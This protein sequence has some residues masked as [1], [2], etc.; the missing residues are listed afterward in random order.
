MAF[1]DVIVQQAFFLILVKVFEGQDYLGACYE[2][3]Y[4]K[5]LAPNMLKNKF[6]ISANL[7]LNS[8]YGSN[9]RDGSKVIP[10]E[11]FFKFSRPYKNIHSIM[12]I[13]K[14]H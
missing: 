6:S 8:N 9:S 2:K 3:N 1:G 13:I 7:P 14:L 11:S 4:K 5:S 12:R 10:K